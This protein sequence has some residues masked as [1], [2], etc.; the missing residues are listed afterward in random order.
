MLATDEESA[1]PHVWNHRDTLGAREHFLRDALIWRGH[2]LVQGRAGCLQ[3]IFRR[4]L[5]GFGKRESRQR[6]CQQ[7]DCVFLHKALPFHSTVFLWTN[8]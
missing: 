4:W 5:S 8:L 7:T 1:F 6:Q 2:D 3:A